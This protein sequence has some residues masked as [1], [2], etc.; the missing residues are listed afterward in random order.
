MDRWGL[1][2]LVGAAIHFS[3][4][5]VLLAPRL[6]NFILNLFCRIDHRGVL[7]A[8]DAVL[9]K[10]LRAVKVVIDT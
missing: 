5:T 9:N 2:A 7:A 3:L 6:V 8:H 10:N 4:Q 1:L